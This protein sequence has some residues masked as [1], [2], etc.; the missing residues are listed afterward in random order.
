MKKKECLDCGVNMVNV[1]AQR[2]FCYEC[3]EKRIQMSKKQY[4]TLR[5]ITRKPTGNP[6]SYDDFIAALTPLQVERLKAAI[7]ES[8]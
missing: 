7:K 1:A 2:R 4:E 8:K 3:A 5:R 6:R